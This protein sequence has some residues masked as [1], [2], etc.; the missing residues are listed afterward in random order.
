MVT[1]AAAQ[2][3]CGYRLGP[4]RCYLVRP[5]QILAC[6]SVME[7]RGL[8]AGGGL[9]VDVGHLSGVHG[10]EGDDHAQEVLVER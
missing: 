5:G 7:S 1:D 10:V 8:L 2:E 4:G 9:G 3:R 6:R